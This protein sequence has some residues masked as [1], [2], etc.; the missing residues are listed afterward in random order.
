MPSWDG[1]PA[2]GMLGGSTFAV[3]KTSKK[4]KAAVEFATWMSTTEEGIKARIES[5]TSSAF[6]AASALRPVAK[7]SFDAGFYGGEDI[8]QVFEGAATSIG[9]NWNWG[10]TTGTT[11]TTMKDQFGK[12]ASGGTTI[13]DAV[14][15]GHD[16]TVAELKK[17]GLKVEDAG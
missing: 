3:T 14:K 2:S 12:V 6:P 8:Y 16:A 15:A 11:N 7:K 5:G 1:K 9:Q 17:R 4:A 10:P 13:K